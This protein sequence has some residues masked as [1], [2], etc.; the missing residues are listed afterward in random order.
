MFI[1]VTGLSEQQSALNSS[2]VGWGG[3]VI[4]PTPHIIPKNKIV[5]TSHF[6]YKATESI[7]RIQK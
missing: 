2:G 7:G 5:L 3:G 4:S 1:A 6:Q